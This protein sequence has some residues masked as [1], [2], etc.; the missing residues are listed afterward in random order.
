MRDT[1]R[2]PLYNTPS[3]ETLKGKMRGHCSC[4]GG[5][6]EAIV[7]WTG[8]GCRE[9]MLRREGPFR[10]AC[11]HLAP[12]KLIPQDFPRNLSMATPSSAVAFTPQPQWHEDSHRD[13][14]DS[15]LRDL[16]AWRLGAP[17][18]N[19]DLLTHPP[20]VPGKGLRMAPELPP[21]WSVSGTGAHMW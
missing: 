10:D 20:R 14:K 13:P 2:F 6:Q 5:R 18:E 19:T 16:S 4:P 21:C 15:E 17:G 7:T 11:S 1:A 8:Q 9:E 12:R 3:G